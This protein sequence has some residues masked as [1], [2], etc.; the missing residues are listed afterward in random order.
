VPADQNGD[1]DTNLGRTERYDRV[2]LSFSLTNRLGPVVLPSRTFTNGLV[3]DSRN[4]TPLSDVSPVALND[5]GT[6]GMQHMAV[7]KAIQ[8]SFTV[9]NPVPPVI[10]NQPQSLS[11]AQG[12]NAGFSV[13]AGGT[14]PLRY[15]WRFGATNIAG[16]TNTTYVRSNVQP[17]HIGNYLVVVTNSVGSVT[18]TPATLTLQIPPPV[19]IMVSKGLIRWQGLSNLTYS[20]QSRTNLTQTNWPMLG[21]ASSPSNTIWFTNPASTNSL[22]LFRVTYP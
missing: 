4:Y 9:T 12:G 1:S 16:A 21:T 22:R 17:A 8:I 7:V 2:L 13:T 11:V 14:S 18:S 3:F 15:Q 5:S 19:P 6:S 10:T 20:V